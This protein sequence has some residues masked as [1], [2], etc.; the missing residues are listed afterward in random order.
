VLTKA[1]QFVSGHDLTQSTYKA[2]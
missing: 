1:S 2:L